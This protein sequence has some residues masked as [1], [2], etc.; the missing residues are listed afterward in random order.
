MGDVRERESKLG[1]ARPA[2][3]RALIGYCTPTH[4][5]ATTLS[6]AEQST[7]APSTPA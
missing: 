1:G 4:M 6:A 7:L 2:N 5:L 3:S